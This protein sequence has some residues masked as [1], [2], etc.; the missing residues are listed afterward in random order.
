MRNQYYVATPT[1]SLVPRLFPARRGADDHVYLW[2][3]HVHAIFLAKVVA[4]SSLYQGVPPP[5]E[6]PE[7]APEV[8]NSKLIRWTT[9]RWT[10]AN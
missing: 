3:T 1:I 8:D 10:T 6:N 9:I 7:S 4:N 5:S 2:C